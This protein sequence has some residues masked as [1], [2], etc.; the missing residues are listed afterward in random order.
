MAY[1]HFLSFSIDDELTPVITYGEGRERERWTNRQRK[2]TRQR[3]RIE[4]YGTSY[5]VIKS[6]KIP[7]LLMHMSI[8]MHKKFQRSGQKVEL[9]NMHFLR[10]A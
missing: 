7:A 1:F 10:P 9:T 8:T 6:N 5:L 4:T 3:E 2:K